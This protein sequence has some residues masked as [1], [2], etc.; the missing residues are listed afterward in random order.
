MTAGYYAAV[1]I[2]LIALSAHDIRT[3]RVPNKALALLLPLIL[4]APLIND[5]KG[6]LPVFLES[7]LGAVCGFGILLAAGLA[8][9]GGA[10]IGGGDIKLAGLLGFAF[11][12]YGM[13]GILLIAVLLAGP[14]GLL[15]KLRRKDK[16]L[17]RLAFVPFMSAGSLLVTAAKLFL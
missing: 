12:P 7:L 14:I 8:S 4:F 9:K 6:T 1:C 2:A 13:I 3:R 11:G 16:A 17:I 10:G 15:C 5:A